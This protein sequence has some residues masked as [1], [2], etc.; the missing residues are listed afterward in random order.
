VV[1]DGERGNWPAAADV[2]LELSGAAEVADVIPVVIPMSRRKRHYAEA[3]GLRAP[4]RATARV[5]VSA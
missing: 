1:S 2:L 4:S 5:G 3:L